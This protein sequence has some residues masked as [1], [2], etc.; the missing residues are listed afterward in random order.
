MRYLHF[1][2]PTV[3]M[4]TTYSYIYVRLLF[5]MPTLLPSMQY[6]EIK[7]LNIIQFMAISIWQQTFCSTYRIVFYNNFNNNKWDSFCNYFLCQFSFTYC[8]Y[9]KR[10]GKNGWIS[11][12]HKSLVYPTHC[13]GDIKF[14]ATHISWGSSPMFV[15]ISGGFHPWCVIG[16]DSDFEFVICRDATSKM[17]EI[18]DHL[19]QL[20]AHAQKLNTPVTTAQRLRMS[21]NQTIYLLADV[22]AGNQ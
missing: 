13:Q 15:S 3:A 22:E 6:M 5:I 4:V 19:G 21:E 1:F 2:E 20:S 9:L 10:V 14:A 8:R 16:I 11:F 7:P 17:S 12:R 18:I